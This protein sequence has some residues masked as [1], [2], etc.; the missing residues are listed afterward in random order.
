MAKALGLGLWG[1][2]LAARATSCW[3]TVASTARLPTLRPLPPVMIH[4]WGVQA[5]VTTQQKAMSSAS[6]VGLAPTGTNAATQTEL[7]RENAAFQ[8]PSLQGVP[9]VSTAV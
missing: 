9:G 4:P 7:P 8:V 3:G 6:P 1:D 2:Q 5:M